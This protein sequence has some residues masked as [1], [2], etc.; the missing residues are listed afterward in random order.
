MNHSLSLQGHAYGLRPVELSDAAL[1]VQLRA[2]SGQFLNRGAVSEVEQR[3]WI[4]RY[5]LRADDYYF[6]VER[7][8]GGEPHG[9]AGIYDVDRS[10]R[11]AEWGRFVMRPGSTAA[12][13]AA[14]LVYRCG[15][16]VLQ[17]DELCCRTLAENAKVVAFHDTCGLERAPAPVTI[18]HNGEPREAVEHRI[19]RA[20]WP[21]ISTHLDGLAARLAR[22]GR[23]RAACAAGH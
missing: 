20:A 22:A 17:M 11:R 7:L 14:L 2:A 3:A 12:I 5:F 21:S 10:A 19:T 23:G 8:A 4:E 16:E 9:V 1:I 13:E 15:F 18:A 6:V